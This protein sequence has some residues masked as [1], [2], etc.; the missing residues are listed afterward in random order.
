MH[1]NDLRHRD[2]L[3]RARILARQGWGHVHP[4]PMVGCVLVK[5]GRVVGE[6]YHQKY[7]GAH[8]EV[9]TL[10]AAGEAARGATAYVSLEPCAHEG[11]TPPCTRALAAAGVARV[12]FGATD[13][14]VHSGG[15]ADALRRHGVDVLG[16]LLTPEEARRDNP[17]FFH[18]RESSRPWVILKLAVSLDGGIATRPGERTD[19][20]GPESRRRVHELRAGAQAILVGAE[21]VRVD[22]PL[23]TVREGVEARIP[24]LRVVLTASGRLPL[25][26]RLLAELHTADTLVLAGP[27][28]PPEVWGRWRSSGVEV[29]FPPSDGLGRVT[30][31]P[32]L[33]GLA[34]RG[35][36]CLLCEGGSQLAG[37]LLAAK[38]VDR[39][40]LF[41]APRFLGRG[42]V[43]GV[44]GLPP[45]AGGR[46]IP[47]EPPV[48]RGNDVELILDRSS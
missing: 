25:D 37:S 38:L 5:D 40:H 24:P 16:P 47:V 11:K 35:I 9:N 32:A 2:F 17:A 21:T 14:G 7:G 23:L 39:I 36:Q 15:G 41:V 48:Q 19:L 1:A 43:P 45:G 34:K 12:V 22:D 27:D 30:L 3:E 44:S 4:N 10:A 8:A 6:G 18:A 29:E 42:H 33:E 20:T 28:V 13:G 31:E 46:W 26:A